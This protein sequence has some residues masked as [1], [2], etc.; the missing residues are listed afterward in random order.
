MKIAVVFSAAAISFFCSVAVAQQVGASA[1]TSATANASYGA[2]NG[3]VSQSSDVNASASANRNGATVSDNAQS[4]VQAQTHPVSGELEG[5]LDSKTAKTG[6]QVVVKTSEA[7]R[8]SD[9]VMI[10]K[11]SRIVGHVTQ[12]QAHGNGSQDSR[13]GIQFD[14]AE[15][16]NGE[17]FHVQSMIESVAPPAN[18]MAAASIDS[19]EDMGASAMGGGGRAMGGGHAGGGLLGGGTSAEGSTAAGAGAGLGRTVGGSVDAASGLTGSA[20][21]AVGNHLNGATGATG[22]LAAHATA[23]PGV[24]LRAGAAG[25]ASGVLSASKHNI[26]LDSGTQMTLGVAGAVG[27]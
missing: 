20:G 12:V 27:R 10:P 13:L 19:S 2:G 14:R 11:G 18:A 5:K 6:D 22:S 25:S 4:S 16:K 17:S 1:Q 26:H 3:H 21:A 24:M 23:V 8:T 9:G 7:F 15:L